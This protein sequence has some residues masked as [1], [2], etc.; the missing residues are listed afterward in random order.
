[1]EVS[2]MAGTERAPPDMSLLFEDVYR[3]L[4]E[5]AE[6]DLGTGLLAL[7]VDVVGRDGERQG[8]D[9]TAGEGGPGNSWAA[10]LVG[11]ARTVA[12]TRRRAVYRGW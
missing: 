9:E 5:L 6:P 4:R 11:H 10:E 1:M 12:E 7:Q 8:S 2:R 3:N